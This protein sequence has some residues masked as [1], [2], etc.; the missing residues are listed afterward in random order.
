MKL[1]YWENKPGFSDGAGVLTLDDLKEFANDTFL[2]WANNANVNDTFETKTC[3][4][5]CTATGN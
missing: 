4:Y 1:F 5:T 3:L 2:E